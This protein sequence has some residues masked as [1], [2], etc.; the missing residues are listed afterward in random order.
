VAHSLA[1]LQVAHWAARTKLKVQGALLVAPPDP[2]RKVF[3]KA[4]IGFAPV[5]NKKLGFL[6]ILVDS[7]NDPYG[8][9]V[10]SQGLARAWGSR[11][12]NF[13]P[14]GHLNSESRLRDWPEGFRL[15]QLLMKERI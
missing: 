10:F 13:G 8:S 15:L 5:P 1:C 7:S 3:P 4:A 9:K 2:K 6:S 14:Q 12:I 11:L